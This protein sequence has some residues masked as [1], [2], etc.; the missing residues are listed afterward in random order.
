MTS[1]L[2]RPRNRGHLDTH[3]LVRE[4][5]ANNFGVNAA[6][7]GRNAVSGFTIIIERLRPNFR[8]ILERSRSLHATDSAGR[9]LLCC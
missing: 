8:I 2:R 9:C 4:Y 5:L 1:R 6:M 7:L 3:P